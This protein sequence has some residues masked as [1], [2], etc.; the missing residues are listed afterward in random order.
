MFFVGC[1]D[2]VKTVVETAEQIAEAVES[3]A[4]K[5]EHVADDIGNQL[6]EGGKL[7]EVVDFVEDVARETAKGAHLVDEAIEKVCS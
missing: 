1:I 4:E 3:V 7:R 6:P 5:I 2:E